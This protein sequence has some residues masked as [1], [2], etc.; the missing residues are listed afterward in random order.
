MGSDNPVTLG[1]PDAGFGVSG[2][3][4]RFAIEA[5]VGA[6]IPE[7]AEVVSSVDDRRRMPIGDLTGVTRR[8]MEN[9]ILE[10]RA[11]VIIR[12]R[13]GQWLIVL[14][15]DAG[16]RHHIIGLEQDFRLPVRG[17][18]KAKQREVGGL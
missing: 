16:G 9:V 7:I 17:V 11:V 2:S 18:L 6:P 3:I 5:I 4:Y 15:H 12:R 10:R 14:F 1:L 8:Q 13:G